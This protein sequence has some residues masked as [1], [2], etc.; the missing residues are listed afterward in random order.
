MK[1]C[2]NLS[3][4][5]IYGTRVHYRV[6]K[7]VVFYSTKTLSASPEPLEDLKVQN[8]VSDEDDFWDEI[9]AKLLIS[10]NAAG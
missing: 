1:Y 8:I 7:T 4:I 3:T 9:S 10:V 2:G 6:L 5:L